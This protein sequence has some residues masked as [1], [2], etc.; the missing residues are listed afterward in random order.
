MKPASFDYLAVTTVEAAVRALAGADAK[1]L[2][3]GQ[4][5]VP[6]MNFRLVQPEL[7]VDIN[8]IAGLAGIEETGT[9]LKFGALVRHVQSLNSAVAR[10][11]F[12][13]ISEAMHHVAHVAIRNRGTIGGSLVHA[14]PAAEW[15]LLATLLDA[16]LEIHGPDG[17]RRVVPDEFFIAPLVAGLEDGEILTAVHLPFLPAGAGAAF[18]EIAQRAGDFAM[19]SAGAVIVLEDGV[20]AEARLALGGVA[21]TPARARAAEDFLLGKPVS[22]DLLA[23]ASALAAEGLEPN[24]DMHASSEYR[25]H[26]VPTMARRVLATAASRARGDLA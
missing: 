16:E 15:P 6:M 19:V 17:A 18:D 12:P 13:I 24:A 10:K 22:R 1:I 5:L 4:S 11:H 7:L 3:G 8:R 14:D 26:L 23:E 25:L 21:E 2:A 20:I 9:G